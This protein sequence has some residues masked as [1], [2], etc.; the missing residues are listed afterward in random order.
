MAIADLEA[1]V[2]VLAVVIVHLILVV[3]VLERYNRKHS[4]LYRLCRAY[5]L[6]RLSLATAH[7]PRV[8]LRPLALHYRVLTVTI[9]SPVVESNPR[10]I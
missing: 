7:L 10:C 9:P 6:L 5:V 2:P 3:L 1:A 8:A 4:S